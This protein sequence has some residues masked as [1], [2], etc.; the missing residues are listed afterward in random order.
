MSGKAGRLVGAD[1]PQGPGGSPCTRQ[2]H[3]GSVTP[4]LNSTPRA[5]PPCHQGQQ[6]VPK[7]KGQPQES[8]SPSQEALLLCHLLADCQLFLPPPTPPSRLAHT[9]S[10]SPCSACRMKL[11]TTRPSFMCMRGPNVLKILATRTSTP[12]WNRRRGCGIH[13]ISPHASGAWPINEV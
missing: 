5:S 7:A 9:V 10:G 3:Q 6:D 8:N 4:L 2:G 13:F 11:L 1:T 12:S